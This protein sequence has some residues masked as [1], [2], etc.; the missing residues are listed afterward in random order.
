MVI[1]RLKKKNRAASDVLEDAINNNQNDRVSVDELMH[2]LHE[3][4]FGLLLIIFVLPNCVPIPAP[5]LTSL[6][7]I[8]IMFLAY[9]L[10]VG[11]DAPWLPSWIAN[12]TIR[13]TTLAMMIAKAAPRMK[14]VEKLL[15]ARLSFASSN[16]GERVVGVFCMLFAI[17]IALPLPWTNFIPGIGILVM[18]LGL[19]SR[20]G[21]TILIGIAIG[22]VG[23]A[24]TGAIIILGPHMAMKLF[25]LA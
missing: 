1:K 4:G 18:S 11:R 3:R 5:G 25:G 8:P 20:D 9:Q 23:V 14:K 2:A 19:L 24:L 17:S 12:K 13:R 15:R 22:S 7:A 10:I 21:V 6:T 16:T